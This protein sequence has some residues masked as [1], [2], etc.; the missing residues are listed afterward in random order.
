MVISF[1]S[2]HITQKMSCTWS[3]SIFSAWSIVT[4]RCLGQGLSFTDALVIRDSNRAHLGR[5]LRAFTGSSSSP[6]SVRACTRV[7]FIQTLPD[8]IQSLESSFQ[9]LSESVDRQQTAEITDEDAPGLSSSRIP[10]T[11]S[12]TALVTRDLARAITIDWV[13]NRCVASSW[14][15]RW[16]I[17]CV[18]VS[19]DR[20]E[21]FL[22]RVRSA[23]GWWLHWR[24]CLCIS[25]A[26]CHSDSQ[27]DPVSSGSGATVSLS[28]FRVSA[29]HPHCSSSLFKNLSIIK[30]NVEALGEMKD[31]D[32]QSSCVKSDHYKDI[33]SLKVLS[34]LQ[35]MKNFMGN[36]WW[37]SKQ[38]AHW[39]REVRCIEM[40]KRC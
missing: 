17:G 37:P 38:S 24:W 33:R 31:L 30:M 2:S 26:L 25:D 32:G 22:Q 16:T 3:G 39:G 18:R 20:W 5:A 10:P 27:R 9:A 14:W 34:S 11:W 21:C 13:V 1:W 4:S 7:L 8:R 15:D 28:S 12:A 40:D 29:V 36:A 23:A 6:P 35:N 19:R